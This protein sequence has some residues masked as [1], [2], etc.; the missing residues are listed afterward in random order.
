SGHTPR[1]V[2]PGAA[3]LGAL[4]FWPG[5][6]SAGR[7][8]NASQSVLSYGAGLGAGTYGGAGDDGHCYCFTVGYFGGFFG[9]AA[10]CS[11]GFLASHGYFAY[12]RARRRPDI[13]AAREYPVA[14]CRTGAGAGVSL[15]RRLGACLWLC[16]NGH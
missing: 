16:G 11:I 8:L 9:Y 6:L 4:L 15:V 5:G 2:W 3:S 7:P 14:H 10:G 13:P 12:L 1:L